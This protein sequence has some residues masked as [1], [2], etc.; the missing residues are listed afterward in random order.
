MK[1]NEEKRVWDEGKKV[2]I[3][4]RRMGLT[5]LWAGVTVIIRK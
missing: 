1:V 2:W 3:K 5:K 4:M